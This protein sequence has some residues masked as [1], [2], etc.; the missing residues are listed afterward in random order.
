[1]KRKQRNGVMSEEA[2]AKLKQNL[3]QCSDWEGQCMDCGYKLYG[4]LRVMRAHREQCPGKPG[5]KD[6]KAI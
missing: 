3:E 4:S 2:A 5:V 6:E 1:M